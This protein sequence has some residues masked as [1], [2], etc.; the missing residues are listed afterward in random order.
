MYRKGRRLLSHGMHK[1]DL[2]FGDSCASSQ[3]SIFCEH[4]TSLS[5]RAVAKA[6]A[7]DMSDE[8]E[9]GHADEEQAF[10]PQPEA[11]NEQGTTKIPWDKKYILSVFVNI[12]AAVGLVY[13]SSIRACPKRKANNPPGLCQQTHIRR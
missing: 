2:A 8:K 9:R 5:T 13:E 4:A 6:K 1:E 10:L 11:T 7:T 3:V 12:A